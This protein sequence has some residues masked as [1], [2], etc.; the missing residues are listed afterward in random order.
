MKNDIRV[1]M[2]NLSKDERELLMKLIEKANSIT[3]FNVNVGDTFKIADIEFIR[4]PEIN[5]GVPIV[6]K[7]IMFNSIFDDDTNNF[8]ESKLLER[9]ETEVLPK[10]EEAVG[11][12]NVLEFETDLLA[13]DGTDEYGKMKSKISLPTFDFYR[14]NYKIFIK[15]N[16]MNLWWLATSNSA[17]NSCVCY[18]YD[19]GSVNFGNC[20]C[21]VGVRPFYILKSSIFES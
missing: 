16:P 18:V 19:D 11:T 4:F 21:N 6:S 5:G 3:P 17:I 13:L 12:E 1:N 8:A 2:Q 9:L 15:Y 10:I 7:D 14:Q 20:G